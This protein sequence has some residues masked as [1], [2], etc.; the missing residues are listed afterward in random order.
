MWSKTLSLGFL[1]FAL[2]CIT[3]VYKVSPLVPTVLRPNTI[4]ITAVFLPQYVIEEAKQEFVK[5]IPNEGA[6]CFYGEIVDSVINIKHTKVAS[7]VESSSIAMKFQFN[8]CVIR[9]DL[10]G[11]GHSHLYDVYGGCWPSPADSDFLFINKQLL[12]LATFCASGIG[13]V[14]LQDGRVFIF[15]WGH[16]VPEN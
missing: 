15:V 3:G 6:V 16:P 10:V 13:S 7:S 5:A 12:F 14:Q 8:P 1:V 11:L 9:Q 4:S 2:S